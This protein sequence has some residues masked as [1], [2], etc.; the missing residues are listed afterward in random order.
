M[1]SAADEVG[2]PVG[3]VVELHRG[4]M[5]TSG[6]VDDR[7]RIATRPVVGDEPVAQTAA[8]SFKDLHGGSVRATGERQ[9][10]AV[11]AGWQ[12]A[13]RDL[14]IRIGIDLHVEDH[15]AE[16]EH[17]DEGSGAG[18]APYLDDDVVAGGEHRSRRQQLG[19]HRQLLIA[20]LVRPETM[21][22]WAAM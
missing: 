14:C 2:V 16:V 3:P 10:D 4:E 7:S 22:R 9:L 1:I 19:R 12:A 13:E 5:Q 20:P 15:V 6:E 18:E 21:C 11:A 17:R 8:G